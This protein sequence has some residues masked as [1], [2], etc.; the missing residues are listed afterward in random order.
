MLSVLVAPILGR[1]EGEGIKSQGQLDTRERRDVR[2]TKAAPAG[3]VRAAFCSGPGAP[4]EDSVL[5]V[6]VLVLPSIHQLK[7]ES[8]SNCI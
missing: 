3:T 4:V 5:R 8:V 1:G 7:Q 2:K 6:G